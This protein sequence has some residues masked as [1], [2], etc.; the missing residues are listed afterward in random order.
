[1]QTTSTWATSTTCPACPR[2][3]RWRRRWSRSP[4]PGP[5]ATCWACPRPAPCDK[6]QVATLP[7]AA[8]KSA[9]H[10]IIIIIIITIPGQPP[11][12][13]LLWRNSDIISGYL[14]SSHQARCRH[15]KPAGEI[16]KNKSSSN[17]FALYYFLF[18][19]VPINTMYFMF[20][21]A[22]LKSIMLANNT[23]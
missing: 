7:R 22:A 1:M 3:P 11:D 20:L 21:A 12:G 5:G 8:R 13:N 16:I 15:I 2:C 23:F 6:G 14:V 10:N 19:L 4:T 18:F 9:G 17:P